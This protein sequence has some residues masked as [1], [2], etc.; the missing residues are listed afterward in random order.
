MSPEKPAQPATFLS[1]SAGLA[2]G[3]AHPAVWAH[4]TDD[5][6]S[7][8]D[9]DPSPAPDV[10]GRN[11]AIDMLRGLCIVSMTTA[12]LAAGSWPWQVFHVAVLVDG[13]VGFVLLS[14]IVLGITQ[15]RN[16]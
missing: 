15:H 8:L 6:E 1:Q 13:A 12:H 11:R 16:V 4:S 7:A 5:P 9:L 14:G 10:G 3:A 2:G